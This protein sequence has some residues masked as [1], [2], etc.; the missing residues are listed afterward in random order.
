MKKQKKLSNA[1]IASFCNQTAMLL[2]A[3][4]TPVESINILLYDTKAEGG[5]QI[6]ESI[7]SVCTKGV[8]LHHGLRESGVFP[9][10]VIRMIAIGEESGNLDV[11]MHSLADYY[12]REESV[13]TNV[14]NALTYPFIMLAMMVMVIFVLISKVL[15]IFKQ[16]FIQLGSEMQG[17]QGYLIN[18]GESLNRYSIV[19]VI[20]LVVIAFIYLFFTRTAY[21]KQLFHKIMMKIPF[22]KG[23]YEKV[24]SGRFASGMALTLGSGMDTF[25]SLNMVSEMVGNK[26][27]EQKIQKCQSALEE[28]ASLTDALVNSGIFSNLYSRMISVGFRTGTVDIVMNK[29]AEN[30]E[31]ETNRH[32]NTLI[33]IVE[34]TLVIILSVVVGFILLSVILPLMGIMSSIG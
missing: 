4:I 15:P 19:I 8:P 20:V 27:M 21:G 18:L 28:G 22:T 13:L 32:L 12:D 33:S 29:I 30:Y 6:L 31:K 16:V 5:R 17:F 7:L 24:A 3:G 25:T 23:F 2:S 34:P 11:V 26:T 14:R 9:E 1:E 10:Y